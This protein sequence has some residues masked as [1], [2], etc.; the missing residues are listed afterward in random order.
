MEIVAS[1][2]NNL[3]RL[4]PRTELEIFQLMDNDNVEVMQIS[5]IASILHRNKVE[6]LDS[7]GMN[8]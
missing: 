7:R 3:R 2:V 8:F 4:I 6:V 5:R 1:I